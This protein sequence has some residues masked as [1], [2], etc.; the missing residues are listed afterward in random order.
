MF[1][2]YKPCYR[3]YNIVWGGGGA[4]NIKSQEFLHLIVASEGDL[5]DAF[6]VYMW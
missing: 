5:P 2:V 4:A 6:R 3:Y 1:T